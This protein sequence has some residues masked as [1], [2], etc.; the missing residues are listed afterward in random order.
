VLAG[1]IVGLLAQGAAPFDAAAVGAYVHGLAGEL[2]AR[3][4][5]TTRSVLASDVSNHL[6]QALMRI[7]RRSFTD[8]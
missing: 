2:A 8:A 5:G 1:I 4:L 7:E 3:T 6:A